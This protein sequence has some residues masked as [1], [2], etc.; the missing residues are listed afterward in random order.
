MSE[1]A[2]NGKMLNSAT[3]CWEKYILC[4]GMTDIIAVNQGENINSAQNGNET[5]C[6]WLHT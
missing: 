4:E 5:V 1:F 6:L 2:D 3:G